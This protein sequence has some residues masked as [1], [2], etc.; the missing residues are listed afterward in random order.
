MN[1]S[2]LELLSLST[3]RNL[4]HRF[5]ESFFPMLKSHH[6]GEL[7]ISAI[8]ITSTSVR[9]LNAYL[10]SPHRCHLHTLKCNGNGLGFRAVK[11]IIRTLERSNYSLQVLELY[12]NNLADEDTVDEDEDEQSGPISWKE[13]ETALKQIL[14]RNTYLKR[15]TEKQALGLIRYAR[16]LL[17]HCTIDPEPL[18]TITPTLEPCSDVCACIPSAKGRLSATPPRSVPESTLAFDSLPI[19]LQLYILSFLA[20]ILSPAQRIRIYRYASN[21]LTLPRL[22]PCLPSTNARSASGSSVCVPDPSSLD[23][24]EGGNVWSFGGVSSGGGCASGQCMGSRNSV[25]CH[26]DKERKVWLAEVGC[27]FYEPDNG[28]PGV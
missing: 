22:L 9:R 15:E 10:S 3:N 1:S 16:T 24:G 23:F 26:R 13:S 7:H 8:G 12:S 28:S 17:L 21:P 5:M 25:V 4:S 27:K 6:L 2:T 11:S 18:P 19:E 14:A 20:P